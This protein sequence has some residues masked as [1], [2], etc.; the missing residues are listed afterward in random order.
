MYDRLLAGAFGAAVRQLKGKV[1]SKK[2]LRVDIVAGNLIL[3]AL[4]G[5][6]GCGMLTSFGLGLSISYLCDNIIRFIIKYKG[7]I[8]MLF[9]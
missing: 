5:Y 6:F 7:N 2:D 9:K 4:A 8:L 3:G 1:I